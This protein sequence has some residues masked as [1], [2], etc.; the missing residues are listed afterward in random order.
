MAIETD[1]TFIRINNSYN[2]YIL[3][4]EK[5]DLVG[6]ENALKRGMNKFIPLFYADRA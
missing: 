2:E 1:E 5:I 4:T 6:Q 3:N